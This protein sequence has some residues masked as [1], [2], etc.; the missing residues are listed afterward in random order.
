MKSFKQLLQ[1]SQKT[2][3][4]KIRVAGEL[5]EG[6]EDRFKTHMKKF[7]VVNMG[8]GKRAPITERPLDFPQL[9]NIEVTTYE[10]EVKY[11]TTSHILEQYIVQNCMVPHSHVTVRGEFDPIEEQQSQEEPTEYQTLLTT[12]DMGGVS[13]QPNV[14]TN[15]VMDL[16]KELETARKEREIDPMEGAP[17]GDSKDIDE[18][19]NTKSPIGS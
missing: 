15:R 2:Y 10:V 8:A 13:D 11:P 17:K 19:Q 3:K 1:E 4:F 6:F 16:L 7:E 14:G 12:E 5:P 9:Q 18:N